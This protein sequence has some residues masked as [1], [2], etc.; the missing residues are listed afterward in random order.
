[1]S[2]EPVVYVVDDNDVARRSFEW[3]AG[4]VDLKVETYASAQEFLDAYDPE[5]PGCLVLDVRMP[6]MSGLDLLERLHAGD[7]PVPVIVVTAYGDVPT[8][9]RSMKHGALD[10][11]EKPFNDQVMIDRINHAM[12]RN[13][14]LRRSHRERAGFE[15]RM[16]RLTPRELEVMAE[17]ITGKSHKEIA[18]ALKIS[19]KTV[20]IHKSRVMAKMEA[21]S[22]TEL[23]RTWFRF[24]GD[25]G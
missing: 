22:A 7:T 18:R 21:G 9:V 3:L 25:K 14:V 23:A 11:I 16:A 4:S 2:H 1:M 19:P 24:A 10:V 17:I 12:E 5:R 8:T 15:A 20:E 6:G 13:A